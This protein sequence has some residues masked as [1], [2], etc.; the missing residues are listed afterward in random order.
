MHLTKNLAVE[1]GPRHILCNAI[2]P[3]FFPTKMTNGLLEMGGGAESFSQF[4]P[5]GRLGGGEDIAG[6]VVF[7]SSRAASHISG[8]IITTDG[9]MSLAKM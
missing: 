8:A 9:G 6:L 7:L 2:A 1:L 5:N 4:S 3:G